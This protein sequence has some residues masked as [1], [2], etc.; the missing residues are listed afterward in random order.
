MIKYRWIQLKNRVRGWID[1]ALRGAHNHYL[2]FLPGK[3]GFFSSWILKL[4]FSGIKINK[5]QVLALKN[6]QKEGIVVYVTKYKSYFEYLFYYTRYKQDALAFPEIGFD[7]KVVIWQPVSRILRIFLSYLDYIFSNLSLPDPYASGYIKQELISGRSGLLS[8]V[9]KK[10]FYRRFVKQ[11]TDPLQYLIEIQQSVEIGDRPIFIVPQLIFFS[12]NPHKSTPTITD[13]LFGTE[14]KPGKIRRLVALF[15]NPEKVF[16]EISEPINLKHFLEAEQIRQRGIEYQSLVLRRNLL[17]Q[18]NRHRQ[19][20]IGPT[21]KSRE[22]LKESIL[23]NDRLQSFMENYSKKR[24]VPIQQVHK[25]ANKYLEEIAAKYNM[26]IIKIFAGLIGWVVNAI[27]EGV[28]VNMDMLNKVKSM[29]KKGPLILIP[30]HKSHIDYLILSYILYA[31][32]MP[33]PLVAAGK[34]LSFWPMGSIFRGSGAFFIR[35]TF[36]GAVLYSKVFVEY[37][38][39]LLEEGFNIEFF[40]EG[41]RSRTGKLILP[42]LGLLSILISAYKDGA[43]DDMIFVPIY[44]GYDRV[45]E[46]SAYLNEIEGGQKQPENLLQIIKAR[47]LLKKRYGKIYVKFHQP[48]SLNELL[49]QDNIS[50]QDVTSKERNALTRNLGFRIINAINNVSVV[51]S[52]GLVAS[53]LLNCSKKRFTYEHFMSHVGTYMNYLLS[54]EVELADTLLLDHV[55]AVEQVID[56]YLNRK[57]ITQTSKNM[58]GR[59]AGAQ[60]MV[61]ENKRPILEYY[62][63]NCIAFFIPAAFTALAILEKDAFQFSASDLNSG[64]NFLQGFFKNEFAYN[65][66]KTSEYFIRKNIKAF[67]DEAVLI[68]H[69]TLPDTYNLTSSGFRKLKLFSGFLKTYFESYLIVLK[70]LRRLSNSS[71]NTKDVLKKI[72]ATGNRMYKK[73]EIERKEALSKINYKNAVDYFITHGVKSSQ[74]TE[75]IEYY[76][77]AIQRYLN[78]L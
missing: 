73:R 55:Y 53:A 74:D 68:P 62:K 57:F 28:S 12:K 58:E 4:F 69:P 31:N 64:Y 25:K 49:S 70:H 2:C 50:I 20:T 1:K 27:F 13:I 15:K 54:Q 67:I 44:I 71:P 35:R 66:D 8:L 75:K 65:V 18:I 38:Y 3:T 37:I 22:E 14:E 51:T 72:Q 10:G 47:K 63:N 76:T 39:K 24:N 29:S 19:S 21:L 48:I 16:M 46:E 59:F 52:H 34:N 42:K 40:I 41:G 6:L 30:C 17:L 78:Y 45:M 56:A 32:N 33:C 61:N 36:K 23:T 9:E 43:C 26:V 5:Q 11:K 77:K 60:F 7:Y